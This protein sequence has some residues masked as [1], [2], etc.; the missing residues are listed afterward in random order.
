[1]KTR[2]VLAGFL[3]LLLAACASEGRERRSHNWS[4]RNITKMKDN[5][6]EIVSQ[7][8]TDELAH[9]QLKNCIANKIIERY[10]DFIDFLIASSD[11]LKKI[12]YQDATPCLV[13]LISE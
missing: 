7:L 13:T 11:G 5:I 6:S 4:D 9:S 12:V 10:P 8:T 1:M 3:I 2:V